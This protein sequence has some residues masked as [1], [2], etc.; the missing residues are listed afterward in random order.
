MVN[1]DANFQIDWII[2]HIVHPNTLRF[3]HMLK[4][5][6]KDLSETFTRGVDKGFTVSDQSCC[7][8]KNTETS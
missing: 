1:V 3:L 7:K 5:L 4:M 6:L 8:Q 2:L